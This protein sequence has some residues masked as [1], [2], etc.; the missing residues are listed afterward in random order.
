MRHVDFLE[1]LARAVAPPREFGEFR[2][3]TQTS[4]NEKL[5]HW[6]KLV[7]EAPFPLGLYHRLEYYKPESLDEIKIRATDSSAF[8]LAVSDPTLQRQGLRPEMS[9]WRLMH[10]FGITQM[11]LHQFSCDCGGAITRE[12][13]ADRIRHLASD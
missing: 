12:Q 13:M 5:Q 2:I 7:S 10:F 9:V 4:R 1:L 3:V 8:G 11:Q 6:A